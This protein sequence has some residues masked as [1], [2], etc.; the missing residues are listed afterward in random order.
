MNAQTKGQQRQSLSIAEYA[1]GLSKNGIRALRGTEGTFWVG[2]EAGTLIRLPIF[3]VGPPPPGEVRQVL[4]RG[5]AAAASYLL[6]PDEQHPANAWLYT[7]TDQAYTLDR[8]GPPMRRNV[9]RGLS[10]LRIA[11][12][13]PSQLLAC[14]VQA[15]CDNRRRLHLSDGTPE[16]FRRRFTL[17][18]KC[19]GHVFLGAWK[20]DQLAAFLSITEVDDHAEIEGS[21]SMDNL[22]NLRPNDTLMYSVLSHYLIEGGRRIVSYGLSSIQAESNTGG[23]HAFK[24]KVGFE[25]RPVHRAFVPH[26]LLGVLANRLTLWGINGVL[27]LQPGNRSLRKAAGTLSAML[28]K[29]RLLKA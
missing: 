13:A 25:A 15:F 4:W 12:I 5:R 28:G 1:S 9:R 11:P 22:L 27:R 14:G 23:L 7:C 26:P 16:E 17:R 29:G 3:H 20:E 10:K 2:F 18:A 24:T 19:P 6:E 8:L 21:F